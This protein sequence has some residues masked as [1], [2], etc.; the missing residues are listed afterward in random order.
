MLLLNTKLNVPPVR[1][2]HVQR[3]ELIQKL[4]NLR[5]YKLALIVAAAGYGK[6]ALV[7]EWIAQSPMRA[8]WF[9]ID[10]G[11]ND[12]VRFWD[13]VIAAIQTLYPDIGEQTLT[14]LHEPQPLPIETILSTLINELSALPDLL[15][16]VL[17][18]YHVIE[19]SAIHD[20]LAFLVEHMPAEM[21]L[22][23]TTR[24]DPPLPLARMR[25]R[26][27]LL[28]LRSA[29]L[30]FSPPQIA[31]FFTDVMGLA[32]TPDEVTA[33]RAIASKLEIRDNAGQSEKERSA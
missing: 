32:L 18:D 19:S 15:T 30:R 20:G 25:V 12:P 7:S 33:R 23:M 13:Y 1:P 14:L 2:S 24:T 9:S 27:Q 28:E 4:D 26:S 5:E 31:T 29:D 17:D 6:T 16:L 8:V 3:I 11:D 22:I 21:R 10:A